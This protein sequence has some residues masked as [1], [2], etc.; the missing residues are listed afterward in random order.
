MVTPAGAATRRTLLK[1]SVAGL[2]GIVPFGLA[3]CGR[4][5]RVSATP[6]ARALDAGILNGVLAIEQRTIAAYTAAAPLLGGFGE[7]MAGQF[8]SQELLH[9]GILRKLVHDLGAHPHNPL[10]HYEF[11]APGGRRHLLALLH[12]LEQEQVAAYLHA[13]PR[14]STPFLRQTLASVLAN[15]AQH[16]AV[17]RSQQ[18]ITALPGPFLAAGE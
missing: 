6:Q 17:L 15:D 3:G 2:G 13:I 18:G 10:G 8:L 5:R 9:A 16:V 11:G 1:A 7:Q 12:G 4:A 14:M